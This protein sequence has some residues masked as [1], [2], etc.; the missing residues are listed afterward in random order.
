[1][2]LEILFLYCSNNSPLEFYP[3]FHALLLSWANYNL[4]IQNICSYCNEKKF[5]FYNQDLSHS[6]YSY[7]VL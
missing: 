6:M 5:L 2:I 1:M 3:T 7:R 4:G